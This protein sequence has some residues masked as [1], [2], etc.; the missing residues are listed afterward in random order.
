[1]MIESMATGTPVIAINLGAVREVIADRKTG[2]ICE[3]YEQM[4]AM[5]PPGLQL[6]RLACRQHIEN[7]FTVDQ[8]VNAYE[9]VYKQ[10]IKSQINLNSHLDKA[11]V[12]L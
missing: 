4:A 3:N 5:I 10:I 12:R 7:K 2:F 6:S 9:A 11:Q 8:M 1:V